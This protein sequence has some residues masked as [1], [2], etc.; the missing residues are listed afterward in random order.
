MDFSGTLKAAAERFHFRLLFS[1]LLVRMFG[2]FHLWQPESLQKSVCRYVFLCGCCGC[3]FVGL[4]MIAMRFV[5]I[6]LSLCALLSQAQR[7]CAIV[8]PRNSPLQRPEIAHLDL[9]LLPAAKTDSLLAPS[10]SRKISKDGAKTRLR[11]WSPTWERCQHP[12]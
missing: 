5:L 11:V 8:S 3:E 6:E 2:H 9:C 1:F 7:L 12:L 10:K 4:Y